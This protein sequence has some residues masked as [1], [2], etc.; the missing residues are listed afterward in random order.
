VYVCACLPTYVPACLPACLCWG[1][2][3]MTPDEAQL[4]ILYDSSV[5]LSFASFCNI[6]IA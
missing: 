5:V 4:M 1:Q 6:Y 2:R 3:I